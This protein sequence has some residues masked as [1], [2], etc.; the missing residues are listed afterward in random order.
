MSNQDIYLISITPSNVKGIIHLPLLTLT[1]FKPKLNLKEYDT[2]LFTSKYAVKAFFEQ[3]EL[4]QQTKI[5]VIGI[6]TKKAVIN[7]GYAVDY[8]AKKS[9][10]K[11]LSLE[12][13]KPF[14]HNK[15]LYL[16]AKEVA[17]DIEASLSNILHINS[18]ILY[19][20]Q[21][22]LGTTIKPKKASILIFTSPKLVHCFAKRYNFEE[23]QCIAI[24]NSTKEAFPHNLD[25]QIPKTASIA[26]CI[27]LAQKLH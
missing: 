19:E 21:C 12:I 10:A 27:E 2:L 15:I 8:I 24:G 20:T 18:V 1:T 13:Q 17:F 22:N 25:I 14:K 7:F 11:S 23:Y 6:A 5:I 16:R 9:D 26:K 3:Y 4:A